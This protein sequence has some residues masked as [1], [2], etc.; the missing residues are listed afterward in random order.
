MHVDNP[1]ESFP[2][3]Y[4]GYSQIS[5]QLPSEYKTVPCMH[6]VQMVFEIQDKHVEL[7]YTHIP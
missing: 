5:L 3:N 7:H 6:S 2:I 1:Y 4:F